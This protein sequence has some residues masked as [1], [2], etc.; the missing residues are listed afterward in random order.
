MNIRLSLE[1]TTVG[2]MCVL[3]ISDVSWTVYVNEADLV[4]AEVSHKRGV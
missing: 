4:G 1:N 2:K 3:D